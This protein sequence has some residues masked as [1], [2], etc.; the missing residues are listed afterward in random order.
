MSVSPGMSDFKKLT[1]PTFFKR[2]HYSEQ[3]KPHFVILSALKGHMNITFFPSF[4]LR[5]HHVALE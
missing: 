2:V 5:L 3:L 1:P 4:F